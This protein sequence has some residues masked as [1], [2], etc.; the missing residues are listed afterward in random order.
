METSKLGLSLAALARLHEYQHPPPEPE[1][2][3]DPTRVLTPLGV[4]WGGA[5]AEW[6]VAA[7]WRR[8]N[9]VAA[10][11]E[12]E[13]EAAAE[14]AEEV[15]L[16][17]LQQPL[18]L[19]TLTK[20]APEVIQTFLDGASWQHAMEIFY[21]TNAPRFREFV[22]GMEYSIIMVWAH[23]EFVATCEHLLEWQL[24][25][26]NL[27][28]ER[29]LELIMADARGDAPDAIA[30]AVA[31]AV[32]AT[33]DD[34]RDFEAFG[35]MMR[36]RFDEIYAG[37]D[38]WQTDA[39][40][41]AR[42]EAE[43]EAVAAEHAAEAAGETAEQAAEVAADRS[44]VVAALNQNTAELSDTS[45]L[46]AT[47][48]ELSRGELSA[49]AA[50]AA[51]KVAAPEMT[52]LRERRWT[53]VRVLWDLETVRLPRD[54][55]I[56]AVVQALH[57]A[58]ERELGHTEAVDLL[59]SAFYH[60]GHKDEH[61]GM[62]LALDRAKVEQVLQTEAALPREEEGPY[63]DGQTLTERLA[64]DVSVLPPQS[65]AFVVVTGDVDCRATM[66]DAQ[67]VGFT[68]GVIHNG[69]VI[70]HVRQRDAEALAKQSAFDLNWRADVLSLAKGLE[71]TL[72]EGLF[73]EPER[74]RIERVEPMEGD[75]WELGAWHTGEVC[76]WH[77]DRGWGKV[78]RVDFGSNRRWPAEVH[79]HNTSLPMD[80]PRR[81]LGVGERVLFTVAQGASGRGPRALRVRG[82]DPVDGVTVVP[83]LCELQKGPPE[84][85]KKQAR[86]RGAAGKRGGRGGARGRGGSRGGFRARAAPGDGFGFQ[87][88]LASQAVV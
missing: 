86:A 57:C 81:W 55:E 53:H 60:A 14:A 49:K 33:L 80:A 13:A 23:N 30:A 10:A 73:R 66:I 29:A 58:L 70:N 16:E 68:L 12:A 47:Q 84:V 88:Q 11:A 56:S 48:L 19:R 7:E 45:E 24:D 40:G 5:A 34:A 4:A 44:R 8:L 78:V 9:P 38:E 72:Y 77:G 20:F 39:T 85:A 83:L 79:V 32:L 82:V 67:L 26:M 71:D 21:T 15:L 42:Q 3:P 87:T 43:V 1:P 6:Q 62:A 35:V 61:G 50:V 74:Q 27:P 51:A 41:M 52:S 28:A 75:P 69:L 25:R 65:T 54:V 17:K 18:P 31:G 22:L 59:I 2:E 64:W 76:F 46:S 37:E 36:R 63:S